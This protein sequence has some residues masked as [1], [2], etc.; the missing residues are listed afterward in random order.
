MTGTAATTSHAFD[1]GW[2]PV[3]Q[4]VADKP[5]KSGPAA[6]PWTWDHPCDFYKLVPLTGRPDWR[7]L[8]AGDGP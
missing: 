1:Q 3:V 7:D 4:V 6:R 8:G 2:L 5:S